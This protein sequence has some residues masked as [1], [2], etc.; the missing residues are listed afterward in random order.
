M[1]QRQEPVVLTTVRLSPEEHAFV[2]ALADEER[3][4]FNAQ[5]RAIVR[6]AMP[7]TLRSLAPA[8]RQSRCSG[9]GVLPPPSPPIGA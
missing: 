6:A 7:P 4:S 1:R 3:R 5:I 9:S 2:A 8:E